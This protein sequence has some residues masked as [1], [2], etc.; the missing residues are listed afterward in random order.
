M[1]DDRGRGFQPVRP[2]SS[3]RSRLLRNLSDRIAGHRCRIGRVGRG[4]LRLRPSRVEALAQ[5]LEEALLGPKTGF[6]DQGPSANLRNGPDSVA[7]HLARSSHVSCQFRLELQCF[8]PL[9]YYLRHSS[10]TRG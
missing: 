5:Q 1:T 3:V 8:R 2:L 10:N 4:G 9:C 7:L 6:A